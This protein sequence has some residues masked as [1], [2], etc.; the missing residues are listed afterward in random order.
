[1]EATAAID[2]INNSWGTDTSCTSASNCR[3]II[4]T[5]LYDNWE[6]TAQLSTPK[7]SVFAAGNDGDSEPSAECLTM[8]YNS[9]IN[10]VSV[11]VVAASFSATGSDNSQGKGLLATFSDKCGRTDIVA[12]ISASENNIHEFSEQKKITRDLISILKVLK[13]TFKSI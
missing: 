7:I 4:G 13:K 5:A 12:G 8:K 9:D 11:C 6:D 3:S 2:I 10:K 1:M